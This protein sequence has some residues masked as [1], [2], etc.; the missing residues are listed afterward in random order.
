[1]KTSLRTAGP[2]TYAL[3]SSRSPL[4]LSAHSGYTAGK[5]VVA[6]EAHS[7]RKGTCKQECLARV[8]GLRRVDLEAEISGGAAED[9]GPGGV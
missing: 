9:S 2:P 4:S 7:G 5:E 8:R 3:L 6:D 1:M